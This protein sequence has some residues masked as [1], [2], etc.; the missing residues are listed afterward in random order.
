M[1]GITNNSEEQPI[2]NEHVMESSPIPNTAKST[3]YVVGVL[4]DG[5]V[6]LTSLK[7]IV[8][9]KD[10]FHYLDEADENNRKSTYC[11]L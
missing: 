4:R 9:M 2:L 5:Q 11:V 6:H 8:Q 1:F 3:R 10:T 7:S